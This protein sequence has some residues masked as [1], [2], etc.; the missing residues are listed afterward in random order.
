MKPFT[1]GE[2]TK[3]RMIKTAA[4]LSSDK[5][6]IQ[7]A[8]KDIQLSARTIAPLVDMPSG[9]IQEQLNQVIAKSQLVSLELNGFTDITGCAQLY[10]S[11]KYLLEDSMVNKELLDLASLPNTTTGRQWRVD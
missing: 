5:P 9:S 10:I 7:R 6:D 4:Q 11:I 8:F 2:F 1:N 3:D